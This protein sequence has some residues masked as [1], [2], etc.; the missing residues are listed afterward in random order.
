MV[1]WI[2]LSQRQS[3][4][5]KQKWCE[6]NVIP[7]LWKLSECVGKGLKYDSIREDVF[8]NSTIV[9]R[10]FVQNVCVLFVIPKTLRRVISGTVRST[11]RSWDQLSNLGSR[12]R[13]WWIGSSLRGFRKIRTVCGILECMLGRLVCKADDEAS[14]NYLATLWV[15]F[16]E[17]CHLS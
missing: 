1:C 12:N 5:L 11:C 10:A 17:P 15:L 8:I 6:N 14:W 13:S 7:V 2:L 16:T 9:A 4:H 3:E